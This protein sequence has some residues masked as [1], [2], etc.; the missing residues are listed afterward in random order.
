MYCHK[1][2]NDNIHRGTYSVK[3]TGLKMNQFNNHVSAMTAHWGL[4]CMHE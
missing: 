3:A 4:K 1:E 2:F